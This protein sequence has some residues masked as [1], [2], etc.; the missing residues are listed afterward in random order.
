MIIVIG[1]VARYFELHTGDNKYWHSVLN[2]DTKPRFRMLFLLQVF[3]IFFTF[4]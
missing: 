3:N 1:G 4:V 2:C